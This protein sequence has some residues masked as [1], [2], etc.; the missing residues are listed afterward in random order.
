MARLIACDLCKQ[1]IP[2]ENS[3]YSL[4]CEIKTA[5]YNKDK[6]PAFNYEICPSCAERLYGELKYL[7]EWLNYGHNDYL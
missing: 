7:K 2:N 6:M 4:T 3:L 1:I 5:I